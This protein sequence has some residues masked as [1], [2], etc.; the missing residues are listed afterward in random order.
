MAYY[1]MIYIYMIYDIYIYIYICL[2]L[3]DVWVLKESIMK[4]VGRHVFFSP[5]GKV[6]HK[7]NLPSGY[8]ALDI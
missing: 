1:Y 4:P 2:L 3:F 5:A 6:E 7:V 8:K